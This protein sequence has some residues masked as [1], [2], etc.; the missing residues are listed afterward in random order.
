MTNDFWDIFAVVV[1][2]IVSKRSF[3]YY[4]EA[5]RLAM[6][7]KLS[8]TCRTDREDLEAKEKEEKL[9]AEFEGLLDEE[10][11][12]QSY[13]QQR[14]REM[15][16]SQVIILIFVCVI[17]SVVFYLHF[18]WSLTKRKHEQLFFRFYHTNSTVR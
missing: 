14:M 4:Q 3:L 7:K 17:A 6:A 11:F 12:L 13:I 18:F 8:L 15:M 5:E 16:Q 9:E 10:E 2:N 1:V